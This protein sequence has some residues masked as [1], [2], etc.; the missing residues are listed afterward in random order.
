MGLID[1]VL[2]DAADSADDESD[3]D[4]GDDDDTDENG[5]ST[6]AATFTPAD[7]EG[8]DDVFLTHFDRSHIK[9]DDETLNRLLSLAVVISNLVN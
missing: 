9:L 8:V 3:S 2:D 4:N 1:D 7:G 5:S 6:P